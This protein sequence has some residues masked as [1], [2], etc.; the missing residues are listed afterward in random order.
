M[1]RSRVLSQVLTLKEEGWGPRQLLCFYFSFLSRERGLHSI[2]IQVPLPLS[3]SR[4]L[5]FFVQYPF[6]EI[7][8]SNIMTSMWSDLIERKMIPG[9]HKTR[10]LSSENKKYTHPE[11]FQ[12]LA[13]Q[14]RLDSHTNACYYFVYFLGALNAMYD[15]DDDC[16]RDCGCVR[17][18]S[19]W[20]GG[21]HTVP[22]PVEHNRHLKGCRHRR[23]SRW[24]ERDSDPKSKVHC[25][26]LNPILTQMAPFYFFLLKVAWKHG[27]RAQVFGCRLRY[28]NHWNVL[29]RDP[30]SSLTKLNSVLEHFFWLK[31]LVVFCRRNVR[32]GGGLFRGNL[33]RQW[34]HTY[35]IETCWGQ[36]FS[37]ESQPQT[38][39][40]VTF[41]F[42]LAGFDSWKP[43]VGDPGVPHW[44][45]NPLLT[46]SH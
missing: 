40:S 30:N 24:M 10:R 39:L 32:K 20:V 27:S 42:H 3:C 14:S 17:K 41:H 23:R 46:W 37:G 11:R 19:A 38:S 8:I 43:L 15:V 12:D 44:T 16:D 45:V 13:Q 25:G 21:R 1:G 35:R 6:R 18:W 34:N 36:L 7:W 4:T 22:A 33:C 31:L 5:Y 28:M 9:I 26:G 29:L 2:Q